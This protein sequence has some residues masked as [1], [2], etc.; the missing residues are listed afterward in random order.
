MRN[1]DQLVD[2]KFDFSSQSMWLLE[3]KVFYSYD[4]LSITDFK[5]TVEKSYSTLENL[6]QEKL[7]DPDGN[8]VLCQKAWN[9]VRAGKYVDKC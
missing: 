8:S 5:E 4:M 1:Q 3:N 6:E 2:G 7:V 9:L